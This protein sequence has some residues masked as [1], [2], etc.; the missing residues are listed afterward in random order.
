MDRKGIY[1]IYPLQVLTDQTAVTVYRN[2]EFKETVTPS[3]QYPQRNDNE[4]WIIKDNRCVFTVHKNGEKLR[5][6]GVP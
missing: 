5:R 2:T 1:T 4:Y 3:S 6:S